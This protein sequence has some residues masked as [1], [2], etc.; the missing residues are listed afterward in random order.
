MSGLPVLRRRRGADAFDVLHHGE[1]ESIGIDPAVMRIVERRLTD[2]VRVRLKELEESA[3]A[4]PAE[5][6]EARENPVVAIGGAALVHHL[7]LA[8]RVEVLPDVA[9]DAQDLP[10][11]GFEARRRL[12]QEVEDVL[13]RQ[14]QG[15]RRLSSRTSASRAA[16]ADG[17]VRQRSL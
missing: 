6:V 3:V 11:P 7:R 1:A 14:L 16:G 12:L 13:L 10:L 9:D 15:G 5:L 17:T 8:L 4:D 2:D